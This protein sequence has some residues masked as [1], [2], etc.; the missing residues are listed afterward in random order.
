VELARQEGTRQEET[1]EFALQD[2]SRDGF[3]IEPGRGTDQP[4]SM[5]QLHVRRVIAKPGKRVRFQL[6]PRQ[7]AMAR[8]DLTTTLLVVSIQPCRQGVA[9]AWTC[10][11][12][13]TSAIGQQCW[14]QVWAHC[15]HSALQKAAIRF[16]VPQC[17]QCSH[18]PDAKPEIRR[19][20]LRFPGPHSR[21]KQELTH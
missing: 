17:V 16:R 2:E 4:R 13:L 12:P 1:Q 7:P 15:G 11:F 8:A 5:A 18:R 19:R 21:V 10:R 20:R 14:R 6:V 3:L 9:S